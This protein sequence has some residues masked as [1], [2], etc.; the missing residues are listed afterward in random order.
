M[1]KITAV[2]LLLLPTSA[3][4]QSALPDPDTTP[5][6]INPEV[7]QETVRSTICVRGWTRTVRPPQA[8]TS[9]LKRQQ[10]A[11]LG[12]VD[13]RMSDY[14]LDH[15]VPLELGGAPY[16]PRNLWPEPRTIADGWTAD[17]KDELENNLNRRVC[18]GQIRLAEAQ[19]AIATNWIVAYNRYVIGEP[20]P[21]L[22]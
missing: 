10:L 18:S 8:Y 12:Y 13:Q 5:G 15:L 11:A 4:A 14:E 22:K 2:L 6:A 19:Q 1:M 17:V 7:N 3:L 16:D 20:T 9:A 21:L